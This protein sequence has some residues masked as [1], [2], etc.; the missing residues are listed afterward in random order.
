[1]QVFEN[2]LR[3][4]DTKNKTLVL[5]TA[6]GETMLPTAIDPIERYLEDEDDM[7]VVTA[8]K[9][10]RKIAKFSPSD[11]NIKILLNCCD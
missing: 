6:L 5:L 4:A 8:L 1:M 9:Q 2:L 7:I 3:T 11:V 10:L